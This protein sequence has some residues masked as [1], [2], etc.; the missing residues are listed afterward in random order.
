MGGKKV[1]VRGIKN[2]LLT[3][4]LEERR[5]SFTEV[6]K[7]FKLKVL[8]HPDKGGSLAAFQEV[9]MAV[10]EVLAWLQEYPSTAFMEE[11][12]GDTELLKVFESSSVVSYHEGCVIF[13]LEEE[14][15]EEWRNTLRE[16]FE[17]EETSEKEAEHSV[18]F[19][20]PMWPVVGLEGEVVRNSLSVTLFPS[21]AEP[22][23]MVQGKL[24]LHFVTQTLPKLALSLG[25]SKSK[26]KAILGSDEE[27]KDITKKKQESESDASD[28]NT[29]NESIK[30]LEKAFLEKINASKEYQVSTQA[31]LKE[32]KAVVE[33]LKK[34][35]ETMTKSVPEIKSKIDEVK[36]SVQNV[37]TVTK[38][39]AKEVK[40]IKESYGGL[41]NMFAKL[42]SELDT[43]Q[44]SL[45]RSS[46]LVRDQSPASPT[47]VQEEEV[48]IQEE[49]EVVVVKQRRGIIFTSSVAREI[50]IEQLEKETNSKIEK[51]ET[52]RIKEKKEGC[53]NPES[54]VSAMV[55]EHMKKDYDFAVFVVGSNDITD[56]QDDLESPDVLEKCDKLSQQLVGAMV[57][58]ATEY[59]TEVFVSELTPRYDSKEKDGLGPLATLSMVTNTHLVAKVKEARSDS[60]RLH[61]V[62]QR[63]LARPRGP[64]QNKVYKKDGKHLTVEG[65][66]L[67]RSNLVNALRVVYT[68][69][70]EVKGEEVKVKEQPSATKVK[71]PK[72]KGVPVHQDLRHLPQGTPRPPQ[73]TPR[74]PQGTPRPPLGANRPPGGQF[75]PWVGQYQPH[76]LPPRHLLPPREQV[77]PPHHWGPREPQYPAPPGPQHPD[78]TYYGPP[79][80]SRRPGHPVPYTMG[81][82]YSHDDG[83]YY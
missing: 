29:V 70:P 62:S 12:E 60:V 73:G 40:E 59:S 68:N 65:L 22:K 19:K 30:R 25:K 38:E 9:T 26:I 14:K 66:R 42:H 11:E 51:V 69:I 44:Q 53:R 21:C 27:V 78:Y 56:L 45:A 43:I 28:L 23:V 3:L 57:G 20:H 50:D 75:Q 61:M 52:Y 55:E 2:H 47:K 1:E 76:R 72:V 63:S 6:R 39:T 17:D 58:V 16:Y 46:Q 82:N 54:H 71:S 37:E 33:S 35:V 10:R 41:S 32:V 18:Q 4:G 31:E 49:E 13:T 83:Y 34:E 36:V 77:A 81:H 15:V 24:Y 5:P 7:A 67:F 48:A 74:P 79:A 64:E 8:E 80:P